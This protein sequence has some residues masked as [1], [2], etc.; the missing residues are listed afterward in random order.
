MFSTETDWVARVLHIVLLHP[1]PATPVFME[2][3]IPSGRLKLF[4]LIFKLHTQWSPHCEVLFTDSF[5]NLVIQYDQVALFAQAIQHMSY[6]LFLPWPQ[7]V[8]NQISSW[9]QRTTRPRHR[10]S[11][12]SYAVLI[13]FYE[14]SS[15]EHDNVMYFLNYLQQHPDKHCDVFL[16]I[17]GVCTATLPTIP[18]MKIIRRPNEGYD[19]GAFAC[20]TTHLQSQYRTVYFMNSSVRGPFIP[21]DVHWTQP[22]E[23]LLQKPDTHL[24]G[25]SINVLTNV[26]SN[27]FKVFQKTT[28]FAPPF[29]HVQTPMFAMSWTC[30]LFLQ[31]IGFWTPFL[32]PILSPILSPL[33]LPTFTKLDAI[34]RGE[35]MMSQLVL[36]NGWNISCTLEKYASFDYR[37]LKTDPNPN[38]VCGDPLFVNAYFGKTVTPEEAVFFKT[39]RSM[40][41]ITTLPK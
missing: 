35:I 41:N 28:S 25:A 32:S 36:H 26:H 12:M 21:A 40:I 31:R 4:D 6:R 20:L 24:V 2:A 14:H 7:P 16:A 22:F 34:I 13:A 8:S 27:E 9:I 1:Q 29:T 15:L 39:N 30:F 33:L 5:W 10:S 17:N 23:T 11:G 37:T 18:R 19:F 38:S 3:V